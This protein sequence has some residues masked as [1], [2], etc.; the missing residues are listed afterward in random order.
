MPKA[1]CLIVPRKLGEKAIHL[2]TELDLFN[3]ELKI[4]Q[5]E[6][7]LYLALNSQPSLDDINIF[8]KKLSIVFF[9]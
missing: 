3:R 4:E 2:V 1:P 5:K 9:L 8:D 6:G 7:Y